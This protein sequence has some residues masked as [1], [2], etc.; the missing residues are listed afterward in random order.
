MSF[1]GKTVLVTGATGGIGGA[2]ARAFGALGATV[3]LTDVDGADAAPIVAAI[4]R[5]GGQGVFI[6]CDIADPKAVDGLFDAIFGRFERLDHAVNSAGIDPEHLNDPSWD[7]AL[8]QRIFAVNVGGIFSCMG[9]EISHM[10]EQGGGTIVNLSSNSGIH[11]IPTK[12]IYSASKHAIMGFTRSAGLQYG[13]YG[14][15]INAICPGAT[16]TPMMVPNIDKI[17]G[18][19]DSLN[20]ALPIRRMASA[21]EVADAIIFLSSPA[22]AYMIGQALQFDGGVTAGMPPWDG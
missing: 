9:R 20:A 6:P 12:P 19:E 1:N 5:S 18:G 3:I 16:R 22:C 21:E 17:P 7:H 2:T 8:Y 4:E 14:V 11:G 10:R 13:R 15:R